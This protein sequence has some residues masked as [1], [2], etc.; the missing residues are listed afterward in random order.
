[1]RAGARGQEGGLVDADRGH[2]VGAGRVVDQRR[3]VVPDRSHHGAPADAQLG[4]DGSDIQA[5][6]ADQSARLLPGPLGQ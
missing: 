3:A 1:M 2:A 5:V 6:L 4:G